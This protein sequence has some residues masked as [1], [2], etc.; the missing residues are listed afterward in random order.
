MRHARRLAGAL[1]ITLALTP[2]GI[3]RNPPPASRV[4]S[5]QRA[6]IVFVTLSAKASA[7]H[8]KLF[9]FRLSPLADLHSP[10]KEACCGSLEPLISLTVQRRPPGPNCASSQV[11]S[12]ALRKPPPVARLP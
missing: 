11:D 10:T 6:R 12:P 4:P 8:S 9:R 5:G 7:V 3:R 1:V 2:A